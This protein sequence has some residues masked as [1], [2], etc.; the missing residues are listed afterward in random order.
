MIQLYSSVIKLYKYL[1]VG[2]AG[3]LAAVNR[4]YK[5]VSV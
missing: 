2:M 1:K 4:L 5:T 3:G